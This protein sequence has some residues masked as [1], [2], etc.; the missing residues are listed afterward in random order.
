M[1]DYQMSLGLVAFCVTVTFL[2]GC[3]PED[4]LQ[5]SVDGTVGLMSED[6]SLALLDERIGKATIIAQEG[7]GIWPGISE[8]GNWIAYSQAVKCSSLEE[9]LKSLPS[10]QVKMIE[11]HARVMKEKIL[12]EGLSNRDFPDIAGGPIACAGEYRNWVIRYVCEKADRQVADKLGTEAIEKGKESEIT[13]FKLI[14][15]PREALAENK[16]VATSVLSIFKACFSPDNKYVA[17]L[18]VEPEEEGDHAP[19][20]K[21]SLFVASLQQ[22]M[23]AMLVRSP[24]AF[25]YDWRDDGR[26]IAY[27]QG[28]YKDRDF[29]IG[30][31][32]ET[33]VLDEDGKLLAQPVPSSNEGTIHTHTCTGHTEGHAGVLFYPWT[34]VEYGP[35][36]RIFFSSASLSLPSAERDEPGWSVFCYDSVTGSITDVVPPEISVYTNRA[37]EQSMNIC[38][39]TMSPDKKKMLLPI[40]NNRFICYKLGSRSPEFGLEESEGFGDDNALELAP[41][42]K[43]ND[44]ITCLVSENSRYLGQ[45]KSGHKEIVVLGADGILRQILSQKWREL[46]L[47]TESQESSLSPGAILR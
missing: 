15:A 44:Q 41:A 26:A 43:G 35:S 46:K 8:D 3:I 12:K 45:E 34:K 27:M 24:V 40:Q 38:Q 14:V 19:A 47:T 9:G 18:M 30:S 11:N 6:G 17:Y 33:T 5:W 20:M 25:G 31:L 10:G 29:A 13:Y 16:V 22:D 4:S 36:G 37:M 42:W 39:F 2:S 23:K 28:E 21:F 32:D 1:N 7:V